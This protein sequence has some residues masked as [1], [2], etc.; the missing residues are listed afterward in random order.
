MTPTYH[1]HQQKGTHKMK[2]VKL[3]TQMPSFRIGKI[4]RYANLPEGEFRPAHLADGYSAYYDFFRDQY[5]RN[6]A[7][8]EAELARLNA[9]WDEKAK[10]AEETIK[11]DPDLAARARERMCTQEDCKKSYYLDVTDAVDWLRIREFTRDFIVGEWK[12]GY[13][14][15]RLNTLLGDKNG[16]EEKVRELDEKVAWFGEASIG[17]TCTGHTRANWQSDADE[18][19]LRENRPQWTV[20]NHGESLY[21]KAKKSA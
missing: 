10:E 13:Y 4:V 11:V 6:R 1:T 8:A 3:P 5:F 20:E 21:I 9:M 2:T 12:E 15:Y 17:W 16:G 14:V 18:A 7:D 19:W